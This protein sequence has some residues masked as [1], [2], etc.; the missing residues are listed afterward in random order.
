MVDQAGTFSQLMGAAGG[1]PDKLQK[2]MAMFRRTQQGKGMMNAAPAGGLGNVRAMRGTPG[3][4]RPRGVQPG[5]RLPFQ[6]QR[7][8]RL[9]GI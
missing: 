9:A 3:M 6:R 5:N 8:Q 4:V 7:N 2:L 1:D